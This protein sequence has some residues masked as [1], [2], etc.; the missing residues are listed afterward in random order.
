MFLKKNVLPLIVILSL[1]LSC[2]KSVQRDKVLQGSWDLKKVTV[3]D[4]DGLSYSTDTSC[5]GELVFNKELDTTFL[6][7]LS[8]SIFPSFS[9]S[10][11]AKG[12][13]ILKDDAEYFSHDFL[14]VTNPNP[15]PGT[16][17][18][19]LFLSNEYFKW[20]YITASGIRYHLIFKKK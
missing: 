19:I 7:N 9:D 6:F 16:H 8:Y 14:T 13:Y 10:T 3:Y 15:I 18:R 20:E 12:R 1:L 11:I 4:Y 17:S 2:S 5:I